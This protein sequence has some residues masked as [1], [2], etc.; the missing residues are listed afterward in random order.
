MHYG[1]SMLEVITMLYNIRDIRLV[2]RQ[3]DGV[4]HQE[5]Q[6]ADNDDVDFNTVILNKT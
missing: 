6:L 3:R 2:W 5:S 4:A 1:P